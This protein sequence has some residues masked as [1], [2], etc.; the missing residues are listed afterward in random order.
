MVASTRNQS[1]SQAGF[2]LLEMLVAM[3]VA[4]AILVSITPS[5]FLAVAT[6]IQTRRAEQALQLAQQNF[7][8]ARLL[9]NQDPSVTNLPASITG[10]VRQVA[11]PTSFV[12][13]CAGSGSFPCAVTQASITTDGQFA[14]QTFRDRG[15]NLPDG[16]IS[17]FRMGVR[18]YSIESQPFIGS[19][20]RT[21][22]PL[23]LTTGQ[24]SRL[25]YPLISVYPEV[26]TGDVQGSFQ[27]YSSYLSN[28][29]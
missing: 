26:N 13:T 21:T 23:K 24:G 28:P 12:T 9:M 5:I 27:A 29:Q 6:R 7:E 3:L 8:L 22:A 25:R 18:V 11:P 1:Q 16:T 17:G 2:T 14:I 10:D 15:T 4:T 19:L 20:Q